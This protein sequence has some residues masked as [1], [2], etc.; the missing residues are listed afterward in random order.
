MK[1]TTTPTIALTCMAFLLAATAQAAETPP[2]STLLRF[3]SEEIT[4]SGQKGDILQQVTGS[5]SAV[6]NPSQMSVYK[7]INMMPSLSQQSVD[8]YGLADISN[9]HEAFKFRGVEATAGGVPSTTANVEGLPLTGRPGGGATIYDL[10]NMQN[11][12]IYS[13]VMPASKGLGLANVGGK[14]DMEIKRPADEFGVDVK[15]SVGSNN[16]GRTYLRIDTG[17]LGGGF[18]AF[19]SASTSYAEKWKGDGASNRNNMMLGFSETFSDRVKLEAF[20][21]YSKGLIHPYRSLSYAEI[22]DLDTAYSKDFSTNPADPFYYDYNKNEFEDWMVMA[23]LEIKTGDS[24]KLNIKPYYWSDKGYYMETITPTAGPNLVREWDIEHDLKGV[25]AEYSTK[26][27]DID[28][29]FGY[30]YHT[31]ERPGPPSSWKNYTVSTAGD[32]E[33]KNWSILSNTSSH[34]LHEPFIEAKYSTG[35][36]RIE[37]GLKYVNYTLPSII[38]YTTTDIG[39]VSYDEALASNPSIDASRSATATKTFSRV[40]PNLTLTRFINDDTSIHLAYGENYV[41]HV[42]IYPYFISNVTS[43]KDN[44]ITFQELWDAREM[45]TAQN[46]E[47]GMKMKGTNWSLAPTIYY[48]IHNHKQAVLY[49]P[50]L[51]ATYPMNNADAK[52][53]G[54]ELEADYK[55]SRN[56]KCYGSFSWNRFYFDQ[57]IYSDSDKTPI[58][59]KGDQVPD[60]PEFMAKGMLS[61]RIGDF[62]IS[63]IVRYSS[64][65]YGDVLHNEKIDGAT[66]CD[67]DLTWSRPMLGFNNVDCS[68]SLINVFDKNYVSMISTSDYKTLKTSYQPGVPF[69]LVATLAFHY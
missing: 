8:P 52:G 59:V 21:T 44:G 45:E 32:L 2:D 35:N 6:L 22:S 50:A 62:T 25:L 42:D 37:G 5:E 23:N 48:A 33:F 14:I 4:V 27:R 9:Y 67:L 51:D 18:K 28:L 47:L 26:L 60:A 38:T 17:E 19:G 40:F 65:R 64:T 68:L 49:D 1:K 46:F 31:Q 56:L 15:Q 13:G 24:S 58:D 39:D 16:F 66:V 3:T 36:Y 43:F 53:Y 61:Y 11:I 55:P 34:E 12:T 30:L 54:I 69:T 10:E 63:P 7:V 57:E 41:T 29:D 20:L